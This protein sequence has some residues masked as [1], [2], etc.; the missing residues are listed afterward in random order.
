MNISHDNQ[1]L[2]ITDESKPMLSLVLSFSAFI[3]YKCL[4]FCLNPKNNINNENIN[5]SIVHK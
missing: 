4:L 3:V 2:N 1:F 5:Q